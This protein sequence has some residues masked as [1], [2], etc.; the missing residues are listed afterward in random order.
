LIF[1]LPEIYSKL[2][3]SQRRISKSIKL[4]GH[5][6]GFQ[7]K[8]QSTKPWPHDKGFVNLRPRKRFLVMSKAAF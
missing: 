6:T 8:E 7:C 4:G 5:M 2:I 3:G 1:L